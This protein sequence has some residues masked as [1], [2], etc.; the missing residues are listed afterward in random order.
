M[1]K[2]LVSI[3]VPVY[4]C[5]SF[6]ER[7]LKSLLNQT[8]DKIEVIV[9][10]DGSTDN[11]NKILNSFVA[12]DSRIKVFTQK[13]A[14]VSCA[15]NRGIIEANGEFLMFVDADDWISLETVETC[16]NNIGKNSLV[17][18]M[19][20]YAN[21]ETLLDIYPCLY[22]GQNKVMSA[23]QVFEDI[24]SYKVGGHCVYYLYRTNIIKDNNIKFLVDIKYC[25]DLCFVLEVLKKA[26]TVKIIP[27]IF[28]KYYSNPKSATSERNARISNLQ[29]LPFLRK[30][31]IGIFPEEDKE[32]YTKLYNQTI[33]SLLLDYYSNFS[34]LKYDEFKLY[35]NKIDEVINP[36]LKE[37]ARDKF[38]IKWRIFIFLNLSNCIYLL[39]IYMK[40]YQKKF[41]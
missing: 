25:E 7:C 4:N 38:N 9:V 23:K 30:K 5:E 26:Q 33:L 1:K 27:N 10:N 20:Q 34:N 29:S 28:Y 14:G 16:I 11:S 32:I 22:N 31:V 40:I 12:I 37:I 41:K 35:V 15:R 17:R 18:F 13:N 3:I 2:G 24:I 21:D 6:L 39:Y 19:M 36:M 8:Y